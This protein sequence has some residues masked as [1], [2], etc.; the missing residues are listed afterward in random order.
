M[1]LSYD[2]WCKIP[3]L[4]GN[5]TLWNVNVAYIIVLKKLLRKF[6]FLWEE[7]NVNEWK[8]VIFAG[9]KRG[10]EKNW[11]EKKSVLILNPSMH[12]D[13][14]TFMNLFTISELMST[15]KKSKYY[16]IRNN[17][18]LHRFSTITNPSCFGFAY[19]KVSNNQ[20]QNL[21]CKKTIIFFILGRK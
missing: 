16:K 5:Q 12:T 7:R 10:V 4:N 19:E 1:D 20:K 6:Y 17:S 13:I 11:V 3:N 21:Y 8:S 14:V 18:N 2:Q 15:S 9:T